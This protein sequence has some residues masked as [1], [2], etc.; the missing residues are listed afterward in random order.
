MDNISQGARANKSGKELEVNVESILNALGIPFLSQV[1]FTNCYGKPNS[2]MDFYLPTLDVAIE[3]KYQNVPG[4][5]DQKLPYV[6]ED[7]ALFPAKHGL[8][9]LDGKHY[10]ESPYIHYYLNN[11]LSDTFS[12]VFLD[13]FGEWLIE[14]TNSRKA[15]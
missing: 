13:N 6:V 3:C 8:I 14:Q 11:K 2:K 1:K 10:I 9:I 7:L 4:T 5:A 12:W 15:S